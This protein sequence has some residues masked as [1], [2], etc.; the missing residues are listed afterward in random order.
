MT[1]DPKRRLVMARFKTVLGHSLPAGTALAV[2]DEPSARGEVDQAMAQ[3]LFNAKLAIYEDD[4][5][6]TPVE[7]PEAEKARLAAEAFDVAPSDDEVAVVDDLQ[8]W[9][10]DDEATGKKKGAKV[11]KDD[12]LAIAEREGVTVETD[13]NKAD[14]QRKIMIARAAR[15]ADISTNAESQEPSEQARVGR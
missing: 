6:P 13:D 11:T 12:L 9:Q 5:R 7:T 14:L 3:R 15:A 10:E 2:V 8:V 1:Y 4:H